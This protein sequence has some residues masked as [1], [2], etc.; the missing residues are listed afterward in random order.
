MSVALN[1]VLHAHCARINNFALVLRGGSRIFCP[2]WSRQGCFGYE[3]FWR[4]FFSGVQ[5]LA[6]PA[7]IVAKSGIAARNS[8]FFPHAFIGH[9]DAVALLQHGFHVF[10]AG[11]IFRAGGVC[12]SGYGEGFIGHGESVADC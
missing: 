8:V 4:S 10:T 6:A 12:F 5:P 11:K 1:A 3:H 7:H 9:A 2:L